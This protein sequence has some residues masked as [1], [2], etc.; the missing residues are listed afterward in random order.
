VQPQTVG[1]AFGCLN[2]VHQLGSALGAWIPG[3]AYDASGSYDGVL[4]ISAT[5]LGVAAVGCLTLPRPRPLA[6][7]PA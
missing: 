6:T 1:L 7:A 5:V 3:V 4:A 2:A